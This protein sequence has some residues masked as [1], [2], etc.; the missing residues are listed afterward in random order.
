M[1]DHVWAQ[2]NIAAYV[3]G[4]LDASE[5]ERLE[6]HVAECAACAHSVEEA[7]SLEKRLAPLVLAAD[8]GPALED[9]VI[10]SLPPLRM[11]LRRKPLSGKLKAVLAVA[12]AVVLAVL[13]AGISAVME[14]GAG[15]LPERMATAARLYGGAIEMEASG[16]IGG[17]NKTSHRM[18][19]I[20]G[21]K[22]RV[23][24]FTVDADGFVLVDSSDSMRDEGKEGRVLASADDLAK[25]LRENT[26]A[27]LKGKSMEAITGLRP[28]GTLT[29][30]EGAY[31][32]LGGE[33]HHGANAKQGQSPEQSFAYEIDRQSDQKKPKPPADNGKTLATGKPA[34]VQDLAIPLAGKGRGFGGFAGYTAETPPGTDDLGKKGKGEEGRVLL[35]SYTDKSTLPN[36][37]VN[38]FKPADE[39]AA[40]EG[41]KDKL[42]TKRIDK[43]IGAEKV[44][45]G[46]TDRNKDLSLPTHGFDD[47]DG[48]IVAQKTPVKSGE[49]KANQGTEPAPPAPPPSPRRIIIRTGELEFEIE[50]FDNSVAAILKL[51]NAAKGAFVSTINSDKL[52]NGKVRGTLEVRIPPELLDNFVLDLRKE[53]TKSGELKNQVIRSQEITKQYVDLESKLRAARAMEERLLAIIKDGKGQIKDLLAAEKELGEW[54]TKIEGFEGELRYY[55]NQAAYSTLTIKL[56]EK[57]IRTAASVTESERVQAGLE[58]EDVEKAHQAALKAIYDAKGRVTRSELKQ[59]AAGQFNAILHFEVPYDAAGPLRDRLRQL[60]TMV[61]LQVDRVQ[62]TEDGGPAPKDGK[63]ERGPTLFLVSIYNLANVAPRETVILRLAAADVPAVFSKLRGVIAVAKGHVLN[64]QL[65]EKDRKNITAQVDFDVSR[66]GEGEVLAALVAAGETLTRQVNRVPENDN[67]TDAKVLYRVSLVDA[68][69]IQPRETVVVRIAAADVPAAYQ[70]LR[71]AVAKAKSRVFTAQLNEQ[72]RRNITAQ[73]DFSLRR[74]DEVVLQTTLKG[75]GETLSRQTTRQPESPNLTDAKMLFQVTLFDVDNVQPRETIVVRLA[76]TDVPAAYEKLRS[77]VAEAKGRLLT[78][79]I[80][81]KDPRNV[82]AELDVT[83]NRSEL[84][85]LEA[86][87]TAAGETLSRQ[88]TRAAETGNVTDVKVRAQIGLIPAASIPPRETIIV[89]VAATDVSA[90]YEKLRTTIAEAKGRLLTA[91]IDEKDPRNVK[92]ELDVTLDRSQLKNLEAALAAAGETLQRQVARAAEAANITDARVRVQVNLT[93]AANIPPRETITLGIELSD[94]AATL[95]VFST[96]VKEKGGRVLGTK[97]D[98]DTDGQVKAQ[99]FFLVPLKSADDVVD[100]FKSAGHVRVHKVIDHPDAPEG[101][102]AVA[103]LQVTLS[104]TPLLVPSD[105]G[106]WSQLRGGLAFSLRGLSISASWLIVGLLFVLPWLL[107]LYAV[108][109]L[110]RRLWRSEPVPAA[111]PVVSAGNAPPGNNP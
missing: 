101:K 55:A 100:K 62:H 76:A 91:Q 65:D 57:N 69:S 59:H 90:A 32:V 40:K 72:D 38:F 37:G 1:S 97:V 89:R 99:V 44:V 22:E 10:Q 108:V 48:S 104:N 52:P 29:P 6:K 61:R 66:Q 107:V 110:A 23:S 50:S 17:K 82:T 49:Q 8:P 103:Q 111:V 3:A 18:R 54:R 5:G 92:A 35:W 94:V 19:V 13:G 83:V 14:K 7:R 78:A 15:L 51:V 67:V 34:P 81:E 9:R 58:V 106:L 71:D 79:D 41:D 43:L 27:S 87:L 84:K 96:Q 12:A 85:K 28:A 73:L 109:W 86:A 77:T 24:D 70:K 95:T 42:V 56:Y 93:A 80:N 47:I 105:E 53:L 11:T 39:V 63:I 45:M 36:L 31:S 2:E 33:T 102:L 26:V 20:Q 46:Q 25:E 68:D 30:E 74:G 21:D 4:G 88:V 16:Q 75:V 60:G 64:A 98:K